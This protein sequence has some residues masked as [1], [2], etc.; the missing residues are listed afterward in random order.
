M[1]KMEKKEQLHIKVEGDYRCTGS[2]GCELLFFWMN[3]E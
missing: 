3:N 2:G 1:K